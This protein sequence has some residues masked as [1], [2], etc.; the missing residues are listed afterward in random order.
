MKTILLIL[1]ILLTGIAGFSQQSRLNGNITDKANQTAI[2]G[3]SLS[4]IA[5]EKNKVLQNTL[6]DSI[7]NFQF[8]NLNVGEYNIMISAVGYKKISISLTM[9]SDN[10][11]I[12]NVYLDN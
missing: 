6:S 2:K 5:K 7:G 8:S 12:G 4:L 10:K 11:N 1:S 3:A 9:S